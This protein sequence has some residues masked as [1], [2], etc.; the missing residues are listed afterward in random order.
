MYDFKVSLKISSES[1]PND[2]KYKK[3]QK[4]V[5][6]FKKVSENVL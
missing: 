2:K 6:K 5:L 1:V 4:S 3:C